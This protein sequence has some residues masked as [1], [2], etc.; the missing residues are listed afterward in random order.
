[1]A[2]LF[3]LFGCFGLTIADK[4]MWSRSSREVYY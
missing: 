3:S 1:M 4:L 2:A